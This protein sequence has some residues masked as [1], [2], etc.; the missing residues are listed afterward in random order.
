VEAGK[1]RGKT[2]H[3]VGTIKAKSTKRSLTD[4]ILTLC[5]SGHFGVR[6]A[7]AAALERSA[8]A[9]GSRPAPKIEKAVETR[10]PPE[11]AD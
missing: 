9:K 11:Q 8:G 6:E 10:L 4:Q 3:P 2:M 5:A 1:Q 7:I